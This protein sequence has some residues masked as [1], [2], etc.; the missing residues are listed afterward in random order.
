[1]L[2]CREFDYKGKIIKIRSV[3]RYDALEQYPIPIL[4]YKISKAS[5]EQINKLIMLGFVDWDLIENSSI[6][7][8]IIWREAIKNYL[9]Y[10]SQNDEIKIFKNILNNN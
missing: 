6:N 5:Q 1:M 3:E 4:V 7:Q 8:E 10:L 9:V 2:F